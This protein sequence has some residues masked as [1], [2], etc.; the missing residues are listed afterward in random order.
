VNDVTLSGNCVTLLMNR[1]LTFVYNNYLIN[2]K[3]K[4]MSAGKVLLGVLAGVAAGALV[5]ILFAPAKGSRTR[6]R[7]LKKG[8]NYADGLKEKFNEY[9]DNVSEKFEQ[10]KEEVTAYAQKG[11]DKLEQAEKEANTVKN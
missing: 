9:V 4:I 6:R 8:E 5:G 7:I 1:K 3:Q 11:K 2:I 10:V